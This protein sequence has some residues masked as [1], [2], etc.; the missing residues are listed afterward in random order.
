M[1]EATLFRCRFG[2]F[3]TLLLVPAL[4]LVHLI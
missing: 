2:N 4:L 3:K 1:A